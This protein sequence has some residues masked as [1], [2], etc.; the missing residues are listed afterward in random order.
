MQEIT[1]G[2]TVKHAIGTRLLDHG[3]FGFRKGQQ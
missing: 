3:S 1:A 2:I